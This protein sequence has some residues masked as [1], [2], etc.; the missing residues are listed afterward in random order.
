VRVII[1]LSRQGQYTKFCCPQ[2]YV[3]CLLVQTLQVSPASNNS[4]IASYYS[5]TVSEVCVL[6]STIIN[7]PLLTSELHLAGL[8]AKDILPSV[9]D[10]NTANEAYHLTKQTSL[11]TQANELMLAPV[12][13]F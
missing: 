11:L 8:G 5:L 2:S 7:P 4:T 10:P 9:L 1:S 3:G 13:V 12:S 6:T